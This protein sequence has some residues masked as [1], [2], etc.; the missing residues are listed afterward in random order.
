MDQLEGMDKNIKIYNNPVYSSCT[1]N[2]DHESKKL[3]Y[4]DNISEND[5]LENISLAETEIAD[6]FYEKIRSDC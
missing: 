3:Y 5:T 6:N 4:S 2:N 1:N